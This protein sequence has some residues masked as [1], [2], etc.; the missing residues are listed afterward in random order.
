MSSGALQQRTNICWVGNLV[1][2]LTLSR[3]MT[4]ILIKLANNHFPI[5]KDLQ[6]LPFQMVKKMVHY[7]VMLYT[8]I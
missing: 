7:S 2:V 5:A 8:A 6:Y 3:N 1:S 4:K